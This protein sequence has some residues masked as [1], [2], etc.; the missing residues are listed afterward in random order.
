[1]TLASSDMVPGGWARPVR[2]FQPHN[3]AFWLY[4]ILLFQGVSTFWGMA[5]DSIHAFPTAAT[6]GL[7]LYSIYALPFLWFIGHKDR[8][9]QETQVWQRLDRSNSLLA[10]LVSQPRIEIAR[11]NR[12]WWHR[13]TVTPMLYSYLAPFSRLSSNTIS[14]TLS[15]ACRKHV[16]AHFS[17]HFVRCEGTQQMGKNV[18]SRY[19][20]P[21]GRKRPGREASRASTAR[22]GL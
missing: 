21:T 3:P 13:L 18:V 19:A 17:R 15:R 14:H 20:R 10:C 4:V 12:L 8:F 16:V 6:L 11:A 7:V 1:M 2:F 5:G 9:D 22:T